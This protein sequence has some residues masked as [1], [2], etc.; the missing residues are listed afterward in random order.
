MGTASVGV[1]ASGVALLSGLSGAPEAST[2]PTAMRGM[3]LCVRRAELSPQPPP[4]PEAKLLDRALLSSPPPAGLELMQD[5]RNA[6]VAGAG[7]TCMLS[8]GVAGM[9]LRESPPGLRVRFL[10]SPVRAGSLHGAGAAT[11]G[12][13]TASVE[14]IA[15]LRCST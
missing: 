14:G 8:A 11:D 7:E 9:S 13:M 12:G 3:A 4:P 10:P 1:R 2:S 5:P 15:I 6:G